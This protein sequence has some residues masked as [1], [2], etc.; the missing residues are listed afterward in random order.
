[1][2][3]ILETTI[4]RSRSKSMPVQSPGAG[5]AV[6]VAVPPR[7]TS[8]VARMCNLL[9]EPIVM[10]AM[11]G[12]EADTLVGRPNRRRRSSAALDKTSGIGF[13]LRPA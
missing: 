11:R 3:T 9:A 8:A 12:D 13:S 10:G 1:L 5:S 4:G 7:R 6:A 2:A